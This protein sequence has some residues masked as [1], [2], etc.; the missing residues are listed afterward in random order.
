MG[1]DASAGNDTRRAQ[2]H[3]EDV[4]GKKRKKA[5]GGRTRRTEVLVGAGAKD[6][7]NKAQLE[8]SEQQR[9]LKW[10]RSF[11][12][13]IPQDDYFGGQSDICTSSQPLTGSKID[14]NA[15]VAENSLKLLLQ[16]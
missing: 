2:K 3:E 4:N 8:Y 7:A 16:R 14:N 1:T 12:N 6:A 15:I 11:T 13:L 10:Q 5:G 9:E